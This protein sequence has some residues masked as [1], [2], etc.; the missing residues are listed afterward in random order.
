MTVK[1]YSCY[2]FDWLRFGSG[3]DV[4]SKCA[5]NPKGVC[6]NADRYSVEFDYNFCYYGVKKYAEQQRAANKK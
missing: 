5:N 6:P 3:E 1:E 2:L 4:C